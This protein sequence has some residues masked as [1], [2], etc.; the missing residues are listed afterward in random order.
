M[1]L[2]PVEV[3]KNTN[4]ATDVLQRLENLQPGKGLLLKPHRGNLGKRKSA[5]D[6]RNG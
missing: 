6:A 1:I 2:A 3:A 5:V 4:T